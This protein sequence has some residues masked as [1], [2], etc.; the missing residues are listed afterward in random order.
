MKLGGK[1]AELFTTQAK[2]YIENTPQ[3][4]NERPPMPFP[5]EIPDKI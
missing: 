4:Q 1:Y 3:E 2:H 5:K